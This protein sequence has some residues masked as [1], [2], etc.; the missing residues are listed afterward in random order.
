MKINK[1]TVV[2][3]MVLFIFNI[4]YKGLF[5]GH[6]PNSLSL[7]EIGWLAG[8]RYHPAIGHYD[9]RWWPVVLSAFI[10]VVTFCL[11]SRKAKN[12]WLG[13]AV[14]LVFTVSPWILIL[15]R[16]YNIFIIIL[17][18][19]VIIFSITNS[20]KIRLPI[21]LLMTFLI[22][23]LAGLSVNFSNLFKLLDLRVLFFSGDTLST[24]LHIPLTGFF[25]YIDLVFFIAGAYFLYV[26]NKQPAIREMA[27]F[28]L[29]AGVIFF[30]LL[31]RDMLYTYRGLYIFYYLS[32]VI[33]CGYYYLI[34]SIA[35]GRK[36][37][38]PGIV[39]IVLANV[40]FYQEL[41]YNHFDKKNSSEWGYAEESVVAYFNKKPAGTVYI[42]EEAGGKLVKYFSFFRDNKTKVRV[43]AVDKMRNVCGKPN[44]YPCLISEQ[45]LSFF[46]LTKEDIR[47]TFRFYD[48]LPV[49][50]TIP[51]PNQ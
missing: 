43:I 21:I 39:L 14:G 44:S 24:A 25:M 16:F 32:L 51:T 28:Y 10:A 47:L 45:E 22:P 50:F 18:L 11:V 38:L 26:K 17:F 12:H 19:A 5:L 20:N 3:G 31:S 15:S 35:A 41:F 30:L 48:G 4:L 42:S 29:A 37:L 9:F 40:I 13:L 34:S 1:K 2:L 8:I 27:N 7:Q 49:Y 6:S 46:Q 36:I 33:G 23:D